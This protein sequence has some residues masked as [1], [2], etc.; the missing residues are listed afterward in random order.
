MDEKHGEWSLN[1]KQNFAM[2]ILAEEF[3]EVARAVL[4]SD[5]E[6]LVDELFDMA[7]V[8]VAWLE[9]IE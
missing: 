5:S 7:Q 8:V 6:N 3:G 9:G 1:R 2:T 4:E